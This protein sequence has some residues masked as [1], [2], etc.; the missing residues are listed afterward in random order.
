MR[1]IGGD[2]W[3]GMGGDSWIIR[4][5]GDPGRAQCG[6]VRSRG[7]SEERWE[8]ARAFAR[9]S[10][11]TR[12]CQAMQERWGRCRPLERRAGASARVGK[13]IGLKHRVSI[14][15]RSI[16]LLASWLPGLVARLS[17]Q[18]RNRRFA[19]RKAETLN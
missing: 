17:S 6:E 16:G 4:G 12:K 9:K 8:Y 19:R 5:R 18:T 10:V 14:A 7:E 11:S 3:V 1:G 13:W 2:E 15:N